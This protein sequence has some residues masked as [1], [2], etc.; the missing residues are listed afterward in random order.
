[1]YLGDAAGLIM[2]FV[3]VTSFF[4]LTYCSLS[5]SFF[6]FTP[7]ILIFSILLYSMDVS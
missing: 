4:T 1:L 2:T 3:T 5:C 7:A 6:A